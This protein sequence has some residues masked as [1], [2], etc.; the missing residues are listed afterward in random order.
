MNRN[1]NPF[2]NKIDTGII[3]DDWVYGC[4]DVDTE[5]VMVYLELGLLEA[6]FQHKPQILP[7][8]T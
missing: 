2:E 3:T 8:G 5:K 6:L 4:Q 1:E 7:V